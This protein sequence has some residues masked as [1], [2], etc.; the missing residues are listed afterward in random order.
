[1]INRFVE[2][3]ALT[4]FN[5]RIFFPGNGFHQQLQLAAEYAAMIVLITDFQIGFR[6][7]QFELRVR[8][9]DHVFEMGFNLLACIPCAACPDYA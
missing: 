5:P 3:D 1:M 6:S 9:R 2:D 7:C 4:A 8:L